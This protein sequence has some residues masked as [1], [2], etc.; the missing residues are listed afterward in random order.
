MSIVNEDPFGKVGLAAQRLWHRGAVP[1]VIGA[2]CFVLALGGAAARDW[3][4]YDRAAIENGQVW[5]LL[6]A[7]LVHLGWAHLWPNLLALLLIGGLLEE[8]L[9]PVE[10]AVASL[11]TGFAISAGLYLFHPDTGWYVGLSGVL[12]GLVAC[13]VVM[14]IRARAVGL[15]VAL[16][17]GLALK[18]LWEVVY[19]PVPLTAASVGGAVVVPAHL[20]GA[21]AGAVAGVVFATA[22]RRAAPQTARL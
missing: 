9:N 8:F 10:W 12:H 3:G 7:H 2:C 20:Y 1:L 18:L 13:G 21:I 15:G 14:M 19:G 4:S 17:A 16:G 22:R 5:R 11:V 6:T